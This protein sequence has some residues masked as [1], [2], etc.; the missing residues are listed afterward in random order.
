MGWKSD[1]GYDYLDSDEWGIFTGDVQ[2][3]IN[4]GLMVGS[5][6]KTSMTARFDQSRQMTRGETAAVLHRLAKDS[7]TLMAE[8][9]D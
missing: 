7:P 8:V 1:D 2:W 3:T 5:R 6:D 4:S 9:E